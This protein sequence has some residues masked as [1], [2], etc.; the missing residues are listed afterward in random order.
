M[1]LAVSSGSPSYPSK[2]TGPASRTSPS[3][4]ICTAT[5]SSGMPSYTQPPEVSLIP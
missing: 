5:P 4:P 2:S 1:T 3:A